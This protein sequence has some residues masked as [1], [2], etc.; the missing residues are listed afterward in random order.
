M[1]DARWGDDSRDRDDG[2][3]DRDR[4]RHDDDAST[5]GLGRGPSSQGGVTDGEP[6][7]RDDERRPPRERDLAVVTRVTCSCETSSSRAAA[8]GR[9]STMRANGSTG[10]AAGRQGRCQ[11]SARFVSCRRRTCATSP[12]GRLMR[13]RIAGRRCESTRFCEKRLK[14]SRSLRAAETVG[15]W[16]A[17]RSSLASEGW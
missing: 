9:P 1:F 8:S 12:T 3:R 10:F 5:L 16:L 15:R 14:R 13:G 17:N 7:H 11:P 6:R 4:R 2:R